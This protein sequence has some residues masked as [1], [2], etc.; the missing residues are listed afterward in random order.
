M[1]KCW[2]IKRVVKDLREKHSDQGYEDNE[3]PWISLDQALEERRRTRPIAQ[4]AR[5]CRAAGEILGLNKDSKIDIE[6]RCRKEEE[7]VKRTLDDWRSEV[8]VFFRAEDDFVMNVSDK[9]SLGEQLF[10]VIAEEWEL[11]RAGTNS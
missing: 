5:C 2:P 1:A 11:S 7:T 8:L 9:E 4:V 10:N 3:Q 6:A